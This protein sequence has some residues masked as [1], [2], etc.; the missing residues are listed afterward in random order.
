M[1]VE[2]QMM[3]VRKEVILLPIARYFQQMHVYNYLYC[4]TIV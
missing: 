3:S 1:N 2:L 4:T